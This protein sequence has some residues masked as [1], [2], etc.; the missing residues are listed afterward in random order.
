MTHSFEAMR[1]PELMEHNR[2]FDAW[3]ADAITRRDID[4]L[5]DYK[6]KG[7]GAAVAHRTADH[8][9]PLLLTLGAGDDESKTPTSVIER[10]VMWNSIR[11][12]QAA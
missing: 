9:V 4:A 7:P 1:R 12:I 6:S 8:Y 10:E 11:Y 2:D 3:A 5:M